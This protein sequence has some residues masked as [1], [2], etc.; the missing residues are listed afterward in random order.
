MGTFT[1]LVKQMN[2]KIKLD[3]Y[4][5]NIPVLRKTMVVGVDSVSKGNSVIMGLTS[6]INAALT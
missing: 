4:R 5:L 6:S 2:A 1:M 3:I